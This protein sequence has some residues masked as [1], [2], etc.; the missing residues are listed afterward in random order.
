M[1]S[2]EKRLNKLETAVKQL[3]DV[4]LK[5]LRDSQETN[6]KIIEI[7]NLIPIEGEQEN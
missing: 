2:L 6:K 4:V 5:E 7:F 1:L 3:Q